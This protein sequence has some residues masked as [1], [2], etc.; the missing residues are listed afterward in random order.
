MAKTKIPP[1]PRLFAGNG[2]T[3]EAAVDKA[4]SNAKRANKKAGWYQVVSIQFYADNPVRDYKVQIG[5]GS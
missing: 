5:G 2:P 1:S 4:W 3:I